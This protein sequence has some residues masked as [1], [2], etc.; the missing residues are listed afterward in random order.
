M[1]NRLKRL[2][3]PLRS[4]WMPGRLSILIVILVGCSSSQTLTTE[5]QKAA[6]RYAAMQFVKCGDVWYQ[7]SIG[8]ITAYRN[9]K[10]IAVPQDPERAADYKES[11]ARKGIDWF[12]SIHLEC[13]SSNMYSMGRSTGWSNGRCVGSS[14]KLVHQKGVWLYG[15]ESTW[16]DLQKTK[17]SRKPLT[18]ENVPQ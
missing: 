14:I 18:C 9:L 6:D 11:R 16:D 8:E 4:R 5:A 3:L 1:R 10:V 13:T 17:Q 2:E 7:G 12:G 15:M